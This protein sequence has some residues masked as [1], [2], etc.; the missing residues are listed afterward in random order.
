MLDAHAHVMRVKLCK[1]NTRGVTEVE[2][3]QEGLAG[4]TMI[5]IDNDLSIISQ[6]KPTL[7]VSTM[8]LLILLIK[9]RGMS[10]FKLLVSLA[11]LL[12]GF[13]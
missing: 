7:H 4:A 5:G 12:M 8:L 1:A 3:L 13:L 9:Q 6:V 11:K 2:V 10:F